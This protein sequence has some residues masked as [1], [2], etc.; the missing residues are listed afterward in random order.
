MNIHRPY[1]TYFD[2]VPY[3][4]RF[5]I[6]LLQTGRATVRNSF[7]TLTETL[8]KK[9]LERVHRECNHAKFLRLVSTGKMIAWAT[10]DISRIALVSLL[11]DHRKRSE[12]RRVG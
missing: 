2:T 8:V 1:R 10:V 9:Y 12:E 7:L 11:F 3:R 5:S 6:P 4:F